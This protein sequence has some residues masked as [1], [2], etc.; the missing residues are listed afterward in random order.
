M[1]EVELPDGRVVEIDTDD[2]QVAAQAAKSFLQKGS[3]Q[4]PPTTSQQNPTSINDAFLS[5]PGAPL[6]AEFAAGANRSIADIIDFFG[7]GAINAALEVAGADQRV[8]TARQGLERLT[9]TSGRGEFAQGLAGEMAATA[10]ELAPAA[11]A[12]GAGIRGAVSNLGPQTAL[13]STGRRVARQFANTSPA[14]DIG[15]AIA[16]G[17]GQEAGREIA[18]ETGAFIGGVAVPVA[19]ALLTEGVKNAVINR[20]GRNVSLVDSQTGLP[21]PALQNA[22]DRKGLSYGAVVDEPNLLP[23]V[24]QQQTADDVVDAIIRRKIKNDSASKSLAPLRLENDKIIDDDLAKRVIEQGF[25]AGDVQMIKGSNKV[26]RDKMK[27]ML[28]MKRQAL[29]DRSVEFRPGDVVGDDV[30]E[31]IVFLRR[32]SN[33]LRFDLDDIAKNQLKNRKI[34]TF[35][36]EDEVLQGLDDLNVQ[37]PDDVRLNTVNLGKFLSSKDSFKLSDISKAKS[38]QKTIKDTIDLLSESGQADALRAHRLKRQLDRMIDYR[39]SQSQ[40]TEPG[41]RFAKR[42]RFALNKSIRDVNQNYASTN[43]ELSRVLG[44]LNG[45][46]DVMPRKINLFSDSA[47]QSIGQE[48]RKLVTNYNTRVPMQ[49]ALKNLDETATGMGGEFKGEVFRMVNFATALD[50][51]FGEAARGGFGAKIESA[52]R[53]SFTKEGLTDEVV[54]RGSQF[55]QEK[56]GLTDEGALNDMQKLLIRGK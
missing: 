55:I 3:N 48:F 52:T 33:R 32:A 20:F 25:D 11:A 5:I 46:S 37:I 22:L 26:T 47:N 27:N 56:R 45:I 16:S 38:D 17:V 36:I 53:R 9:G 44:A 43:D 6:L 21:T 15:A 12:I 24:S 35:E 28:K 51:R 14:Q 31:R 2:P 18:G 34:N 10:G 50:D 19:G 23:V 4:V 30:L 1:I 54:R 13:E 41:D 39:R 40:L 42:I 29:D 7:P 8:P 49:D